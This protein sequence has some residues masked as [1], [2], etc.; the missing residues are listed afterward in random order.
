MFQNAVDQSA[1]DKLNVSCV[2][3]NVSKSS[4]WKWI[5]SGKTFLLHQY[6][7]LHFKEDH[8]SDKK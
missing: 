8:M 7:F 6:Y 1:I 3:N 2:Y 4:S 5:S